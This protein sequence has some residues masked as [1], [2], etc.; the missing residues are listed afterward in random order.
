MCG[1]QE[2]A[3]ALALITSEVDGVEGSLE[4]AS[5]MASQQLDEVL[6]VLAGTDEDANRWEIP[7]KARFNKPAHEGSECKR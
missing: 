4:L 6:E 5:S 1:A 3:A 2:L 7:V